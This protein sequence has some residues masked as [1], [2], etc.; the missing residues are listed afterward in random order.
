MTRVIEV[1]LAEGIDSDS[2]VLILIRASSLGMGE[3]D[4]TFSHSLMV[5]VE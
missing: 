1:S 5:M 3:G 4:V 2:N